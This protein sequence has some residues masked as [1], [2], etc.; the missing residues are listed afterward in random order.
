MVALRSFASAQSQASSTAAE[1][2]G[3]AGNVEEAAITGAVETVDFAGAVEAETLSCGSFLFS[4][5]ERPVSDAMTMTPA[6]AN[7]L[8]V[9]PSGK[10]NSESN[11]RS[12]RMPLSR[13]IRQS[14]PFRISSTNPLGR[15][16]LGR[17]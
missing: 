15:R 9:I 16:G 14:Y 17:L 8:M 11:G 13:S 7:V 6:R 10:T 3:F 1:A 12:F 2:A 4:L 5:Q